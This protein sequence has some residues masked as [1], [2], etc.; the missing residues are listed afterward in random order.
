MPAAARSADPLSKYADGVV[1]KSGGRTW[2]IPLS[3]TRIAISIRGGVAFVEMVR[4]FRNAEDKPI[5]ASMTFPVPG[6]AVL[7]GLK[8]TIDGRDLTAEAKPRKE[9][10][11]TY[12]QA[13]DDG[14]GTV[15]H[16]ELLRGVHMLSLGNLAPGKEA[17]VTVCF[18]V[19]LSFSGK[20]PLLRVPT[21]V[22]EVYGRSPLPASD[23]IE[24]DD[25]VLESDVSVSS[26]V[27]SVRVDGLTGTAGRLRLDGAIVVTVDGW[28]PGVLEGVAANG[29][30]VT[31]TVSPVEEGD[32]AIDASVLF[33]VSGST[34]E[35][36]LGLDRV[37]TKR[38]A[39][40]EGLRR[41]GL[42]IRN[43]ETVRLYEFDNH[44][45]L[46]GSASG[47]EVAGLAGLI[48]NRRGG[49]EIGA[50]LCKAIA[51]APGRDVILMTDGRSHSLDVQEI[52]RKGSRIHVVLVGKDALD[53]HVGH[54]AALTGGHCFV[55][56][57]DRVEDALASA[58]AACRVPVARAAFHGSAA[59]PSRLEIGRGGAY[60]RALWK[61]GSGP[62]ADEVGRF[63]AGLALAAM[64]EEEATAMAVAHG[65]CSHLT[66]LVLVDEAAER[67][68]GIPAS[69]KVPLMRS[70]SAPDVMRFAARGLAPSGGAMRAFAAAPVL[71][72]TSGFGASDDFAWAGGLDGGSDLRSSR[73]GK[74]PFHVPDVFPA[75]ADA[76]L[77]V[78]GT[79]AAIDWDGNASTLAKGDLAALPASVRLVLMRIAALDP[80]KALAKQLGEDVMAVSAA[81]VARHAVG[82]R[83][84]DRLRRRVLAHA[85]ARM[86][87]QAEAA[88]SAS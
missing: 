87:A 17:S 83:S 35:P 56:D 9:A 45:H 50:A 28:S 22:G 76:P 70:A 61:P 67:Q 18:A 85:A 84:A 44:C 48:S 59:S 42:G 36:I 21:T 57:A 73:R 37:V 75:P 33:D 88:L 20:A 29:S 69:R 86:L 15:L 6:D 23:D 82:S 16:E 79:A 13:I 66:S 27:G 43:G 11:A 58:F 52:A 39:M 68:E 30:P 12:E 54:L 51:D 46:A 62:G 78:A 25:V 63:A 77:D 14:K 53:A 5:E 49:T 32:V 80:V 71:L 3:G 2:P 10:R 81:L 7:T 55:V 64:S 24:T 31:L 8:A 4:D 41:A 38:E 34:E 1:A 60:I 65:L 72:S 47:P 74:R 40:K 19:P 26:D